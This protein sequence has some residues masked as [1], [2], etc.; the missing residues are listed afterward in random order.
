MPSFLWALPILSAL[1]GIGRRE[2]MLLW[3]GGRG[4]G[5]GGGG[6][7]GSSH[8][9][10]SFPLRRGILG[11]GGITNTGQENERTT[12][13]D[14]ALLF[15]QSSN[16]RAILQNPDNGAYDLVSPNSHCGRCQVFSGA[17]SVEPVLVDP[18]LPVVAVGGRGCVR[19]RASVHCFAAG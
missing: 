9:A 11:G 1:G 10:P 4:G 15:D 14:N 5:G 12:N 2:S 18:L 3:G 6:G 17:A 16:A 19:V 7:V 8:P 13:C